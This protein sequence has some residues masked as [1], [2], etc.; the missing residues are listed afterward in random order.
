MHIYLFYQV[1][2][3]IQMQTQFPSQLKTNVQFITHEGTTK[4]EVSEVQQG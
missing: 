3:L 2:T 4:A 1:R